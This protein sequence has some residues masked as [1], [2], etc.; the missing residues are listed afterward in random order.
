MTPAIT[1]VI[2]DIDGTLIDEEHILKAQTGAVAHVFGSSTVDRQKVVD[3][4]FAANNEAQKRAN[5]GN[6]EYKNNIPWY[7]EYIAQ[8]FGISISSVEAQSLADAWA[9]AYEAVQGDILP[10]ED[11]TACIESLV[12]KGIRPSASSGSTEENRRK[13]LSALGVEQ[14]FEHVFAARTVGFQKQDPRY[15]E[16][17]LATIGVPASQIMMVG[18]QVNDDIMNPKKCGMKT[19]LIDRQYELKKNLDDVGVNADFEI[20]SLAEIQALL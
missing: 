3:Y 16:E 20:K 10:Y 12:A 14:Y 13:I 11:V 8:Q 17:V 2:F 5:E 18:N 9:A 4:F 6:K 1:H 15:W 7:M 19:V